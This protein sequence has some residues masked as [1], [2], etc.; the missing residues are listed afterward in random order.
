MPNMQCISEDLDTK[1]ILKEL[2]K[3][4]N[5]AIVQVNIAKNAKAYALAEGISQTT[6]QGLTGINFRDLEKMIQGKRSI[7]ET[8]IR[9]LAILFQITEYEL[10]FG[11][12][13]E[14]NQDMSYSNIG[15]NIV[16]KCKEKGIAPLALENLS[17][18]AY[19]TIMRV[20]KG[21]GKIYQKPLRKLAKALN[22]SVYS[23]LKPPKQ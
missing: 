11:D 16:K 9:N 10:M 3:N 18:V 19:T 14:K 8:S 6:L 15:P 21:E 22:V 1:V 4:Y 5:K 2:E 20:I 13:W 12:F 17:G 23:L 7:K